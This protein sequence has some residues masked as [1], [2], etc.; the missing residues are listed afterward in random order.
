ME[1][2]IL[3]G[4]GYTRQWEGQGYLVKDCS[5][6]VLFLTVGPYT[7]TCVYFLVHC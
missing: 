2:E 4:G 5:G 3:G 7:L 1:R 6:P